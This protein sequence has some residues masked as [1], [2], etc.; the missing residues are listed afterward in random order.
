MLRPSHGAEGVYPLSPDDELGQMIRSSLRRSFGSIEPP[1]KVWGNILRRV[2]KDRA[3]ATKQCH[4]GPALRAL[5]PLAQV[6]VIS[7]LLV[8]FVVGVNQDV[9]LPRQE[10]CRPAATV[11]SAVADPSSEEDNL[12]V[13]VLLRMEEEQLPF[14]VRNLPESAE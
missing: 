6:M 5:A 10:Y 1:A 14:A 7:T 2:Q 11:Q 4:T 9:I 3:G 8:T 13:Y 12:R